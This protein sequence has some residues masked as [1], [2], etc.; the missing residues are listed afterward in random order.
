M[1]ITTAL[2]TL[3]DKNNNNDNDNNIIRKI[4][5]IAIINTKERKNENKIK[6]SKQGIKLNAFQAHNTEPPPSS[7]NC[8]KSAKGAEEMR[9]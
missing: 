2:I 5:T 8:A 7:R 6:L 9:D 3:S 4:I 1:K